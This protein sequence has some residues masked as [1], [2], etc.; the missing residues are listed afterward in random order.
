M[1]RAKMKAMV[2]REAGGPFQLEEVPVPK[3]GPG[4][5]L[6]KVKACGAGLTIHHVKAGR[7]AANFPIIIGHEIAGEIVE[8]GSG[9]EGFKVG[10]KVT[11]HFY[12]TCGRCKWCRLNRETLCSNFMGYIGRQ[13]NGGYAEYTKLPIRNLVPI[14]EGL[15]YEESPAEV[16]VICDA[17]A[18][19]Y[20]V[21]SKARIAPLENV[22]VIGAGGGVGIHMVQMARVFGARVIAVDLGEEKL[23]KARECGAHEVIDAAGGEVSKEVKRLTDGAGADVVVSF[24]SL[25]EPM[26][27]G[28]NSLGPGGRLVTLG[29]Y[30]DAPFPV[31]AIRVL[32]GEL[33]VIGSKYVTWQELAESLELVAQGI[34]KPIVTRTFP[35]EEAEEAHELLERGE[36]VGRAALLIS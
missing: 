29:G 6:I 13:I 28:L 34:I 12:L 4:E 17:I 27:E 1:A 8:L 20:K 10:D 36:V 21:M 31:D 3:P 11:P 30:A 24:V 35:L 18:T 9:V 33:E 26:E 14:P 16:S 15:P 19:P 7:A 25:R 22:V 2:L 23:T 32:R 5:A